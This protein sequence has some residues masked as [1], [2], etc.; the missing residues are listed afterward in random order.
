M[1]HSGMTRTPDPDT[2]KIVPPRYCDDS[3]ASWMTSATVSEVIEISEVMPNRS[4]DPG[5]PVVQSGVD[6]IL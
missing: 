2:S 1:F 4:P 5:V 3:T 6:T